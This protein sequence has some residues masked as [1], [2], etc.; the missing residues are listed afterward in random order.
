MIP[1]CSMCGLIRD[2]GGVTL[3]QERWVT[4]RTYVKTHGMNLAECHLTHTYCPGCF[5]DFMERVTLTNRIELNH[6]SSTC[7]HFLT[8][9]FT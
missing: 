4:K 9:R 1:I 3:D 8:R 7:F 5:T 6:S 2:A